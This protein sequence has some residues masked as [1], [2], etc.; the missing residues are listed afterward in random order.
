MQVSHLGRSF[1][2]REE[3]HFRSLI[4]VSTPSRGRAGAVPPN[5]ADIS[6]MLTFAQLTAVITTTARP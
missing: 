5:K 3:G 4:R 1:F 6:D 2:G